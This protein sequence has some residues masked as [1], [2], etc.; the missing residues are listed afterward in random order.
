[1]GRGAGHHVRGAERRRTAAGS[2]RRCGRPPGTEGTACRSLAVLLALGVGGSAAAAQSPVQGYYL[3]AAAAVERSPLNDAA[4]L[5]S[6]RLRL[7]ATPRAG[8]LSLDVAYEH[9]LQLRTAPLA[10]GRGFEGAEAA[11][12]WLRLQGPLLERRRADWRHGF[13]RLSASLPLG[14]RARATVGRQTV[15][16]AT[17]LFFTPADP[18]APFDPADPFREFRGG[19]DAARA[20]AFLGPLTQIDA[21]LRPA[22]TPLGTTLTALGRFATV[23]RGFELSASAGALHDE[24]S[25]ALAATGAVGDFALRGEGSLRRVAGATVLRVATGIDRRTTL[26]ERDLHLVFE[27][28]YDGFGARDPDELLAVVTSTPFRRGELQVLGRDALAVSAS[29]QSHPL[30]RSDL[31]L[32]ANLRDG[33]A[34][35][36]PGFVYSAADEVAVRLGGFAGVG[37]GASGVPPFPRSE[38]GATPL[39]GYVAVSVF[40]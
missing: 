30:L 8:S 6:Q 2:D 40:F 24:P 23:V 11:G 34:L 10:L 17:T 25:G 5:D 37:R 35:L 14:E 31:R 19:I 4:V 12:P 22:R 36:T 27:Y 18:F 9:A 3:H 13:D 32:L 7:M 16:W 1:M 20:Q 33:S 21:V 26:L 39:V 29:H 28:Q 15:S 38:Y